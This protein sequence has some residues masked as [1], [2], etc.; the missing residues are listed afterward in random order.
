M[1][2]VLSPLRKAFFLAATGLFL[3]SHLAKAQGLA[4]P[5]SVEVVREA[6]AA[7][8]FSFALNLPNMLHRMVAPQTR[9]A[10]F[11]EAQAALSDS[12]LDREIAKVSASLSDRAFFTL[13]SGAKLRL[14][15]WQWPDK[16]SLRDA[17]NTSL[18]VL[19]LPQ[20]A[21]G[22]MDPMRVTASVRSTTRINRAQLQLPPVMYP[23][24]VVI[25]A[26][27]FWLTDEI[28]LAMVDLD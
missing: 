21:A 15:Q 18:I 14:T 12:A 19:N 26:D 4:H 13:P 1:R 9:Y 2:H 20:Q 10:A 17:F 23:M 16:Q 25:K 24:L 7:V 5:N 28:S 22:H 27:K 3:A 8:S 11:L 6:P